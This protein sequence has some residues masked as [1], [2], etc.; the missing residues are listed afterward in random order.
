MK[1]EIIRSLI[2]EA[3]EKANINPYGITLYNT[4]RGMAA[5]FISAYGESAKDCFGYDENITDLRKKAMSLCERF[6]KIDKP[7]E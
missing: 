7:F 3:L 2:I 6:E 1:Y 4:K 5:A